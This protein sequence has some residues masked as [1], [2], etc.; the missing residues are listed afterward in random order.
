MNRIESAAQAINT[1]KS[2]GLSITSFEISIEDWIKF[3]DEV[4]EMAVHFNSEVKP[5][6]RIDWFARFVRF[7]SQETENLNPLKF[8]HRFSGIPVSILK[9]GH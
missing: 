4:V 6:A 8:P 2:L 9:K 3:E 7:F 1:L 5:A